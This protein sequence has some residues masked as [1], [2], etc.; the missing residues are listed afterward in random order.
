MNLTEKTVKKNVIYRGKVITLRCDD[1]LRADGK[2]C[3]REAALFFSHMMAANQ[4]A[5]LEI[6]VGGLISRKTL[7]QYQREAAIQNAQLL[8]KIRNIRPLPPPEK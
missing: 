5:E 4:I 1:A 7:A 3:T 6:I 8:D 2:P